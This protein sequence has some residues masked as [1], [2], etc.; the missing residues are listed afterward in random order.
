MTLMEEAQMTVHRNREQAMD[1]AVRVG[2]MEI[3]KDFENRLRTYMEGT[4]TIGSPWA[5]GILGLITE[6]KLDHGVTK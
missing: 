1:Y 4:G 5:A 6:T 2:Q 3:L